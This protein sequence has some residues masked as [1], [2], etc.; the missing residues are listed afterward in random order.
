MLPLENPSTTEIEF[1][2]YTVIQV[3]TIE[4]IE[5]SFVRKLLEFCVKVRK[6]SECTYGIICGHPASKGE[7][8]DM[9]K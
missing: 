6:P 8:E 2:P 9:I 1:C 5:V 7:L 3:N 4:D